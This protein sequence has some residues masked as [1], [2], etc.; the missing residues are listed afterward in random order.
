MS[1]KLERLEQMI[2]KEISQIIRNEVKDPLLAG[3]TITDTHVTKDLSYARIYYRVLG[4][5]ANLED[6]ALSLD[7]AQGFV[8]SMLA[9]KISIR[10]VPKL[11][12]E[13]DTS[14]DTGN[15]IESLLKDEDA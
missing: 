11:L 6:V 3:L 10:K 5:N 12:F 9:K 1:I 7:K 8:R 14:L 15:R 13:Y 4:D 2:M